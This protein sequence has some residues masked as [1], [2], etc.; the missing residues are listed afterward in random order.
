MSKLEKLEKLYRGVSISI[1]LLRFI[2]LIIFIS[3][4]KDNLHLA[5][6]LILVLDPL[7]NGTVL[8][9][10]YYLRIPGIET[11]VRELKSLHIAWDSFVFVVIGILY[12]LYEQSPPM[13]DTHHS[14]PFEGVIVSFG[15]L[16]STEKI[17]TEVYIDRKN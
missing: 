4:I 13:Q 8:S 3:F 11:R 6:V 1:C 14:M 12:K 15:I 9:A 2:G 16:K 17:I 10:R 7:I 5:A